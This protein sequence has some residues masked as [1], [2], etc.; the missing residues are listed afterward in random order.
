MKKLTI[1]YDSNYILKNIIILNG[2]ND[3]GIKYLLIGNDKGKLLWK[4]VIPRTNLIYVKSFY[5]NIDNIIFNKKRITQS[6]TTNVNKNEN[7][8]DINNMKNLNNN[9]LRKIH[10]I[11]LTICHDNNRCI[12]LSLIFFR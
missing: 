11:S 1:E 4:G 5:I 10:R 12:I 7:N 9:T 8:N 6:K 3:T 2:F